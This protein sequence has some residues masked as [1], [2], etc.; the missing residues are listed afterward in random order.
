MRFVYPL[1][2]LLLI[3]LLQCCSCHYSDTT[4]LTAKSSPKL[5]LEDQ[6][7]VFHNFWQ[8]GQQLL[9]RL[10]AAALQFVW[11]LLRFFSLLMFP[12]Q[13]LG[14]EQQKFSDE[15]GSEPPLPLAE[16]L[17]SLSPKEAF[18]FAAETLSIL[19]SSDFLTPPTASIQKLITYNLSS[20]LTPSTK[21][22]NHFDYLKAHFCAC[23]PT[24]DNLTHNFD[25]SSTLKL[26]CI[27]LPETEVNY[28]CRFGF[29]PTALSSSTVTRLVCTR[30]SKNDRKSGHT[31]IWQQQ[32]EELLTD[33]ED[34]ALNDDQL[35]NLEWTTTH[36]Q[37]M[38][39][40]SCVLGEF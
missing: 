4:S 1:C 29:K 39:F 25:S 37:Q 30:N 31:W 34:S 20:T 38:P 26:D 7:N 40:L 24:I 18:K 15:I 14:Q 13:K 36:T 16:K 2:F 35:Q 12:L 10:L 33:L 17:V 9:L 27:F 23:P 21:L 8:Y 5:A 19:N 6:R 32:F 22:D 3:F 28:S 11:A